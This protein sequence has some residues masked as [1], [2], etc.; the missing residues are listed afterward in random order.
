MMKKPK[1]VGKTPVSARI[2]KV[3]V[4]NI[5]EILVHDF[6]TSEHD[7]TTFLKWRMNSEI[8]LLQS[9]NGLKISFERE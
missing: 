2:Y 8:D 7:L 9:L 3:K 4:T 5:V 6:I 1:S